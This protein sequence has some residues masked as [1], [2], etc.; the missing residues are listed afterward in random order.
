MEGGQASKAAKNPVPHIL[1]VV[2]LCCIRY[3]HLIVIESAL[4]LYRKLLDEGLIE[5][6]SGDAY[7]IKLGVGCAP[8]H[9]ESRRPDWVSFEGQLMI[10]FSNA[11]NPPHGGIPDPANRCVSFC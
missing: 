4:Y 6:P 3:A 1:N 11:P 8:E 2:T 7:R 10:S 5:R 9:A